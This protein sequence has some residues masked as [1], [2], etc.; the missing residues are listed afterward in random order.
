[1]TFV[2]ISDD[3]EA[4][5]SHIVRLNEVDSKSGLRLCPKLTADHF[6]LP[7]GK[8]MRVSLAVQ[9]LSKSVSAALLTYVDNGQ[10]PVELKT[11]AQF[12]E[13]VDH[14][15]NLMN[16]HTYRSDN[17]DEMVSFDAF[18]RWVEKWTFTNNEGKTKSI[19][20]F[21]KCLLITLASMAEMF[22][23][24]LICRGHQTLSARRFNQDSLENLFSLLRRDRGGFNSNPELSKVLQNLRIASTVNI[25]NI[26]RRTNCENSPEQLLLDSG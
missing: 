4:D 21:K 11:T 19:L 12:V 14:M 7:F 13:K 18:L 8:K 6:S 5:W 23:D 26:D 15:W 2:Q 20:P 16:C 25:L 10:L 24:L 22:R 17:T 1:M 3:E 9:T